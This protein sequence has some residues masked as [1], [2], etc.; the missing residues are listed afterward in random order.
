[1]SLFNPGTSYICP[2]GLFLK[3]NKNKYKTGCKMEKNVKEKK[4]RIGT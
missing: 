2:C 3:Q 4:N 1:M